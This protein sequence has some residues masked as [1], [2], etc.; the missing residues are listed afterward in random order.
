VGLPRPNASTIAADGYD[1]E[2]IDFVDGALPFQFK[3]HAGAK[4]QVATTFVQAK[5]PDTVARARTA[6]PSDE[7]T[8]M[9]IIR[10]AAAAT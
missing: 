3:L 6:G 7:Q 10:A 5:D 1:S 9:S 2:K 4:P 8:R